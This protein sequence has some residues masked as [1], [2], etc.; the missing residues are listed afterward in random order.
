MEKRVFLVLVLALAGVLLI[1]YSCMDVM[2][3]PPL[4][5]NTTQGNPGDPNDPNNPNEPDDNAQ[6]VTLRDLTGIISAPTLM[7][8]P[9]GVTLSAAQSAQYSAGSVIWR[10]SAGAIVP[11]D[12]MFEE[13]V[14]YTAVFMLN[15]GGIGITSGW[16]FRG[17]TADDF[18]FTPPVFGAAM[19]V[20]NITAVSIVVTISFPASYWN[21][22]SVSGGSLVEQLNWIRNNGE[23]GSNYIVTVTG[24]ETIPP[25]TFSTITHPNLSNV[26][27]TLTG[28]GVIQPNATNLLFDVLGFSEFQRITLILENITLNGRGNSWSIVSLLGNP[29]LLM[30]DGASIINSNGS[31]VNVGGGY[32][33]MNGGIIS[34][35]SGSGVRIEVEVN[36]SHVASFIMNGGIISGNSAWNGGGVYVISYCGYGRSKSIFT[37]NG[38]TISG[39]S[40]W[41]GGGGNTYRQDFDVFMKTGGTIEGTGD[42]NPNIATSGTGHVVF[43]EDGRMRN[44]TAG[45]NV[46]MT[47]THVGA[48]GGWED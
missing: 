2:L 46:N 36:Y 30:K 14:A 41:N 40:A 7:T 35:N 37:M 39:N 31:G 8:T 29:V 24:T 5:D 32:F 17:L 33:I 6:Q 28:G 22:V 3:E 16:T 38:G 23:E 43:E 21:N 47:T 19:T 9:A 34:G 45:P 42:A 25:Q 26:A 11:S 12:G 4:F 18:S 1:F 27:I 20:S 13:G 10:N 48:A 44:N 15:T